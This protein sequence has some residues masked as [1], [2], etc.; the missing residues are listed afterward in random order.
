MDNNINNLYQKSSHKN[1][2]GPIIGSVI[3]I[4]V[5]MIGGFYFWGSKV[6]KNKQMMEIENQAMSA[7]PDVPD[8]NFEENE[9]IN[10]QSME[11]VVMEDVPTNIPNIDLNQL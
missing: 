7:F 3:V 5:V 11:D 4:I 2:V 1:G 9:I 10:E 8:I 6:A